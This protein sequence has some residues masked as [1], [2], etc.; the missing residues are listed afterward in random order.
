MQATE[1]KGVNEIFLPLSLVEPLQRHIHHLFDHGHKPLVAETTKSFL[2]WFSPLHLKV[3]RKLIFCIIFLRVLAR[4]FWILLIFL[5]LDIVTSILA[6]MRTIHIR[7]SYDFET[8]V[9]GEMGVMESQR[10]RTK[11]VNLVF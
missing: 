5:S 10:R 2:N 9:V 7:T 1:C 3:L 11:K 8:V 4:R 6:G